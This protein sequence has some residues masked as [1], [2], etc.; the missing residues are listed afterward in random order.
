MRVASCLKPS[1]E[2]VSKAKAPGLISGLVLVLFL[3]YHM[4]SLLLFSLPCHPSLHLWPSAYFAEPTCCSSQ[5]G[6]VSECLGQAVC[7]AG[8]NAFK[9]VGWGVFSG[10]H[11]TREHRGHHLLHWLLPRN[12][13]DTAGG[14]PIHKA[15]G[16]QTPPVNWI[17]LWQLSPAPHRPP[18]C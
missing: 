13:G 6:K 18:T 2:L 7:W 17:P 15:E 11:I 9:A 5:G 1:V 3:E 10:G 12:P 16:S 14:D 8:L 4:D